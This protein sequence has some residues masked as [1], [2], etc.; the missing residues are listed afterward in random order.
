MSTGRLFQMINIMLERGTVTAQELS[1][2]FEVSVRTIYRD[3][4][5]LSTSGIPVYAL[6]GRNGGISLLTNYVLDKS[7]LTGKEQEQILLAIRN[8]PDD[9]GEMSDLLR[10]LGAMFQKEQTDWME[11]DFSRWGSKN[12]KNEYFQMLK[13]AI[14][15]HRIVTFTYVKAYSEKVSWQVYPLKV[16]YKSSAWYLQAYSPERRNR[17]GHLS[18]AE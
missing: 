8:M 1:E 12:R 14:L 16:V 13:E 3:I 10:K 5:T 9:S 7:L 11:V 6:R 15:G 4:D 18:L 17:T 2:K